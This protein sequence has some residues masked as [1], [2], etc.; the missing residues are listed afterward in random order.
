MNK[1]NPTPWHVESHGTT[2]GNTSI[3]VC[4]PDGCPVAVCCYYPDERHNA[5]ARLIASAPDLLDVV[6]LYL[7][8]SPD[9]PPNLAAAARAAIRKAERNP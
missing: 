5:N 1:P 9:Q 6:R 4:D 3:E 7:E 2:K 8:L